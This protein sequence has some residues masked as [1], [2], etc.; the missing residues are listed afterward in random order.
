[1]EKNFVVRSAYYSKFIHNVTSNG[2]VKWYDAA[3]GGNVI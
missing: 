3:T 1:M 2:T